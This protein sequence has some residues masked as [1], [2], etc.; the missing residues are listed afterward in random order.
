MYGI[1]DQLLPTVEHDLYEEVDGVKPSDSSSLVPEDSPLLP[2]SVKMHRKAN[3]TD[4]NAVL[5]RNDFART[6]F[7]DGLPAEMDL[8]LKYFDFASIN[9]SN[10][11]ITESRS[12]F[13]Q[14]LNFG[15]P[16]HS[17]GGFNISM[18]KVTL[19][20]HVSH[21]ESN[22][23]GLKQS[24]RVNFRFFVKLVVPKSKATFSVNEKPHRVSNSTQTPLNISSPSRHRRSASVVPWKKAGPLNLSVDHSFTLFEKKVIGLNVRGEGMVWLEDG[25]NMEIGVSFGISIGGGKVRNIFHERYQRNQLED[26]KDWSKEYHWGIGIVSV[27]FCVAS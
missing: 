3:T 2:G 24:E 27:F 18:M 12:H 10:G 4:K 21:I 20:S 8:D 23:L 6:D 13:A 25:D 11:M 22:F 14:Q 17:N 7:V 9:K 5:I 15:E 19:T 26:G 1:V 16:I